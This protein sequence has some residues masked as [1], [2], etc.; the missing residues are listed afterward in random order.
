MMRGGVVLLLVGCVPETVLLESGAEVPE[1]VDLASFAVSSRMEEA[2]LA[3][4]VGWG[5]TDLQGQ[6]VPLHGNELCVFPSEV[7]RLEQVVEAEC[8]LTS[9]LPV[10]TA[11]FGPPR[12]VFRVT[13]SDHAFLGRIESDLLWR[14]DVTGPLP[15]NEPWMPYQEVRGA[16]QLEFRRLAVLDVRGR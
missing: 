13:T 2:D 10:P 11:A 12:T 4:E 6:V 9:A 16:V 14:E 8:V 1:G 15:E 5:R 3:L 7:N